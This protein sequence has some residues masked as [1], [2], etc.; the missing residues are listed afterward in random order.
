MGVIKSYEEKARKPY[1][2]MSSVEGVSNYYTIESEDGDT[3]IVNES[4][5]MLVESLEEK[6]EGN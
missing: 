3:E 1:S 2:P 5:L 6:K 4:Y